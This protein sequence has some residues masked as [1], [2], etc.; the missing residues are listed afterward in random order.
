MIKSKTFKMFDLVNRIDSECPKLADKVYS[1]N[2]KIYW[3]LNGIKDFPK[4]EVDG[5]L[6]INKNVFNVKIGYGKTTTC[7]RKC[8]NIAKHKHIQQANI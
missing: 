5:N 4:C 7:C 8:M 6:L 1:L 2:T 3:I